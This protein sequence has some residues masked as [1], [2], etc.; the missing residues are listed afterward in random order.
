M[1]ILHTLRYV[2]LLAAGVG[3]ASC[4]SPPNYPETPEI[5][6][7]ALKQQF[8][9]NARGTR[10]SLVIN[11]SYKDGDGD[12]GLNPEEEIANSPQNL[13]NYTYFCV[14][15]IRNANNEFVDDPFTTTLPGLSGRF[16]RLAPAEQGD[17]KAPIE[18]NIEYGL[19]LYRLQ[20]PSLQPGATMRFRIKIQD[21]ALQQSNE[22]FTNSFV[23]TR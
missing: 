21:R 14:L 8:I 6:F 12:L 3:V 9:D 1:S 17:K 23:L 15:Q 22:V 18:G 5:E 11:V 4:I 7:K 16:K 13:R 20:V 19:A 2:S 10:D